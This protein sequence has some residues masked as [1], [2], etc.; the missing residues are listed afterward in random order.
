MRMFRASGGRTRRLLSFL[1]RRARTPATRRGEL[2]AHSSLA[3]FRKRAIVYTDTADFTIR[4][5]RDGILHFLMV[6]DQVVSGL[7]D[8]VRRQGGQ[9]LKVEA[10]SLLL[11][12]ENPNRAC[13]AVQ[14]IEAFL[15]RRNRTRPAN[16]Q[17]RFSY[18]IGYG[19][20]LDLDGDVFG[21]EVNLASK[22]GE[23]LA[24]PGEA[25]LTSSATQALD[26]RTLREVVPYRIVTLGRLS[27]PVHRLKL[28]R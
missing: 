3:L 7:D 6:F 15:R 1:R 17:L 14:K 12:F 16:E 18:G 5:V 26:A 20:L 13:R 11:R 24:R 28:G 2:D 10:D 4:T 21:L 19:N 25:L 27:M 22:L 9:I 23:D 8:V